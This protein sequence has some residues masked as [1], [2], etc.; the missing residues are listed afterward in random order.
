MGSLQIHVV[1]RHGCTGQFGPV[2]DEPAHGAGRQRWRRRSASVTG[3]DLLP[4]CSPRAAP[5]KGDRT[6]RER[7]RPPLH[8]RTGR[9]SAGRGRPQGARAGDLGEGEEEAHGTPGDSRPLTPYPRLAPPGRVRGCRGPGGAR[10]G[11]RAVDRAGSGWK[12]RGR[13]PPRGCRSDRPAATLRGVAPWV[14]VDLLT[15]HHDRSCRGRP[16]GQ[17][18]PADPELEHQLRAPTLHLAGQGVGVDRA[19]TTVAWRHRGAVQ[20]IRRRRSSR[21]PWPSHRLLEAWARPPPQRRW[22][23]GAG[24]RH[25]PSWQSRLAESQLYCTVCYLHLRPLCQGRRGGICVSGGQSDSLPA[26]H[27]RHREQG[28]EDQAMLADTLPVRSRWERRAGGGA[29]REP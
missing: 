27:P 15:G 10:R 23:R 16:R 24:G 1:E 6:G 11:R 29:M 8:T 9:Q 26:L 13:R 19:Y 18:G 5:G 3:R 7:G 20:P 2:G 17:P 21:R 14:A 4:G 12:G 25:H 22:R 28:V